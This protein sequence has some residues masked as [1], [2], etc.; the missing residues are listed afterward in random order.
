[1]NHFDALGRPLHIGDKVAYISR[2]G[3]SIHVEE[4]EVDTLGVTI[5]YNRTAH[6]ITFVNSSGKVNPKNTV[7][8]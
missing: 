8:L 6:Y 2:Y 3:S 1:M 4:R 5:K 7:R